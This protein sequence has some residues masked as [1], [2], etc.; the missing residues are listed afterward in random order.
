MKKININKIVLFLATIFMTNITYGQGSSFSFDEI[1]NAE[2]ISDYQTHYFKNSDS[3]KIAYY[4]F[5]PE[6]PTAKIIFIHGG[7][8]YSELGYFNFAKELKEKYNIE[9]ILI[10]LVGHGNSEGRRGDCTSTESVYKDIHQLARIVNT[11]NKPIYLGGHSSGGG[12]VLNYSSW[13]EN[14]IF[15]GYIFVS[16][17]FGYKS[18]TKKKG[19]TEFGKIHTGKFILT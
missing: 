2:I 18:K 3:L 15:K 10:D 11:D 6:N 8:A 16:P 17:E 1:T 19:R 12:L 13:I 4:S 9:T 5:S 14:S 7:G